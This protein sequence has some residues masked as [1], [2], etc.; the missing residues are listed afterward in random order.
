M[1]VIKKLRLLI[2]FN[3]K[4]MYTLYNFGAKFPVKNVVITVFFERVIYKI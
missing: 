3:Q 4:M 1:F 2:A